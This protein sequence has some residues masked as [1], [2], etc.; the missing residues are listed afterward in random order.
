MCM[1]TC[2]DIDRFDRSETFR[3]RTT[4]Q[5]VNKNKSRVVHCTFIIAM[6]HKSTR[7]CIS[8]TLCSRFR[9]LLLNKLTWLNV[10][11]CGGRSSCARLSSIPT[12]KCPPAHGDY[13]GEVVQVW[14]S[15][16][17]DRIVTVPLPSTHRR[18]QGPWRA[19]GWSMVRRCRSIDSV[20]GMC[21]V[22]REANY[23]LAPSYSEV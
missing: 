20:S 5:V 14:F 7:K 12:V 17:P 1:N 10:S 22:N 2:H 3:F 19:F 18:G 16:S 13:M 21:T 9:A 4:P 23:N 8:C 6:K 11:L 15:V